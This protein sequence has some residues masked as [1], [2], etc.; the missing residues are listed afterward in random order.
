MVNPSGFGGT[1]YFQTDLYGELL[2]R[3][4]EIYGT[5]Q[6]LLT[7]SSRLISTSC[8]GP[9]IQIQHL[10]C[11]FLLVFWNVELSRFST[12]CFH[13]ASRCMVFPKQ[14]LMFEDFISTNF[15]TTEHSWHQ[16]LIEWEI[17][18]TMWGPLVI[19][20]FITQLANSY[21]YHKPWWNW[22]Y[23]AQ[24]SYRTGAPHCGNIALISPSWREGLRPVR[25]DLQRWSELR[26]AG[27]KLWG[28]CNV[29]R[30]L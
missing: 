16:Q 6:E 3:W 27:V 20:W 19:S 7:C 25:N 9:T 29:G 10:I 13:I 2:Q 12:C 30:G 24:L 15:R 1:I 8:G 28:S 21:S 4:E 22:S 5:A 23:S 14:V 17:H 18:H 11:P 26:V